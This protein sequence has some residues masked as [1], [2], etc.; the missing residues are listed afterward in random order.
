MEASL[1]AIRANCHEVGDCW[2]WRGAMDDTAP[3]MRP[4]GSR[5]LVPV[6]RLVMTLA[7]KSVEGLLACAKCLNDRCVAPEH[8]VGLTRK[9]LQQRT[10]QVTRYGRSAARSA[11]LATARRQR[12]HLTDEIVAEMRASGLSTRAAAA[13]FGCGQSAA[14]DILAGRTWKDYSSPFAGMVGALT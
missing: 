14:A 5:R 11:K 2:E 6:R 8:A 9:Q 7:G 3:V 13:A 12:S 10:A 1:E 4:A